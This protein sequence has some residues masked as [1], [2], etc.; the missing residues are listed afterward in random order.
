M[1]TPPDGTLHIVVDN[2]V[3]V[4]RLAGIVYYGNCHFTARFVDFDGNVWFNDGMIHA[5]SVNREGT[6]DTVDLM[7]DVT[8]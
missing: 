8:K 1:E 4:Y 2:T 3:V 6:V 7:Q 5:R